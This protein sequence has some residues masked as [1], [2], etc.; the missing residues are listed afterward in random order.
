[1]KLVGRLQHLHEESVNGGVSDQLKEEQVLQTLQP[2]G[3]QRR[4][5]E[6]ELGESVGERL[7]R[8]WALNWLFSEFGESSHLPC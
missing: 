2:D 1:M 6:E 8:L 3:T 5:P 4:Q 7:V